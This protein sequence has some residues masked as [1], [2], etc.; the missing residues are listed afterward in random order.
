MFR[1]GN[2]VYYDFA[3]NRIQDSESEMP[4]LL[5]YTILFSWDVKSNWWNVTI[6]SFPNIKLAVADA[7]KVQ[8]EAMMAVIDELKILSHSEVIPV[9]VQIRD[10][11]IPKETY[12]GTIIIEN[13][14]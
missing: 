2:V 8:I 10:T 13:N 11:E 1:A 9:N 6:P 4:H 14:V 5:F 12:L 7:E 3:Q